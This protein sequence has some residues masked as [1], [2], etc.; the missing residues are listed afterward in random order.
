MRKDTSEKPVAFQGGTVAREDLPYPIVHYPGFYGAFFAFQEDRKGPITLCSCAREA[1]ENH[2]KLHLSDERPTHPNPT[3]AFALDSM[4]V[5]YK[6]VRQ[7]IDAGV[8]S[9]E[10]VIEHLQ[11]ADRLCHECNRAVPSYR[12]CVQ[13]YECWESDLAVQ[14]DRD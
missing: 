8:P 11:F 10:G 6:L 2:I 3:R 12:Y 13:M 9:D 1:I 5:P 14:Q 7:L 4:Y